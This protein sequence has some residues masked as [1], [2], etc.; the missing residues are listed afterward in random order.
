MNVVRR[1]WA[2][3]TGRLGLVLVALLL[4]AAAFAPLL[5]IADPNAIN[6]R[7]RFATP[8]LAHPFGTD[9]L[10]RDLL[11]RLLYGSRI[12]ML[13]AL[14]VTAQANNIMPTIS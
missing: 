11:S 3:P 8:S 9:H 4:L 1:I 13:V 12:A 7:N 14:S 6:V 5:S 2:N 10:G